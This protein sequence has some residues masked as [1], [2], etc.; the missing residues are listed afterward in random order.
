MDIFLKASA[1]VIIAAILSLVLSNHRKDIALLLSITVCTLMGVLALNYFRPVFDFFNTLQDLGNLD[2]VLL[3][4]MLKC[5][6]ISF[7]G[8]ISAAICVDA[9][10]GAM[11]KIL[12]LLATVLMLVIS[13]P[14]FER[15]ISLIQEILVAI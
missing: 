6:G 7:I 13:V 11:G 2:G 9:G 5:V 10:N 14:L 8:E 12:Q 1:V 3:S 4:T 15:L